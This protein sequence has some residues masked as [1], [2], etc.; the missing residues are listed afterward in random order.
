[1]LGHLLIMG[2]CPISKSDTP[3]SHYRGESIC[4]YLKKLKQ[5]GMAWR[6]GGLVWLLYQ[7]CGG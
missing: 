7:L 6:A 3:I 4:K 2:I 5:F 1:M